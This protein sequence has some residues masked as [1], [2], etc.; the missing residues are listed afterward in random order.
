MEIGLFD[1]RG[2]PVAYISDDYNH[3]IYLWDGIPVAYLYQSEY[4]YGNNGRHLGRFIDN[5]LYDEQ[6]FRVGFGAKACP[7]PIGREPVK[8]KKV[9]PY[10]NR[11]RWK[12][13]PLPKLSYQVSAR[14]LAEFLKQGQ[15]S[16][17]LE[18]APQEKAVE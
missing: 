15:V 17:V 7:V 2:E 14:D 6:G 4:V 11:P 12:A 8:P 10:E 3:T 13:P 9:P 16:R 1:K 5:I 18:E